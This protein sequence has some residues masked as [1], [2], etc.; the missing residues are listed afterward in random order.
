MNNQRL[1]SRLLAA[2]K[3]IAAS[4]N[5]PSAFA[6]MNNRHDYTFLVAVGKT[7]ATGVKVELLGSNDSGGS[8]SETIKEITFT[9]TSSDSGHL[10]VIRGRV[11]PD[12]R[13]MGV[14]VTNLDTSTA[15]TAAVLLVSDALYV[16]DDEGVTV[17]Q[18]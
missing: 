12:Y 9:K 17:V 3:E 13:Y 14:K 11:T 10:F 7:T 6:D 1:V 16:P 18:V 8:G 2:P 15:S 4:G 5:V